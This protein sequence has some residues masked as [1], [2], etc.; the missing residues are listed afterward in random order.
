MRG[1]R[2]PTPHSA[3]AGGTERRPVWSRVVPFAELSLSRGVPVMR[4]RSAC[5]VAA[6]FV[7]M[8][9]VAFFAQAPASG[10]QGG[11]TPAP[12]GRGG[13]GGAPVGVLGGRGGPRIPD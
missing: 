8:L 10:Q 6:L 7:S 13:R 2:D 11:A 1:L 3:G 9:S 5:G 12:G 4:I